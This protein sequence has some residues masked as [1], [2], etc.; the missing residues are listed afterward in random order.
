VAGTSHLYLFTGQGN[1]MAQAF[2]ERLGYEI[3]GITYHKPLTR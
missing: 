3:R 1:L 2:Y